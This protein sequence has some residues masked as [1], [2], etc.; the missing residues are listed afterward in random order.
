MRPAGECSRTG[1]AL[2][3]VILILAALLAIA[4]PLVYICHSN[5]TSAARTLDQQIARRYAL[6]AL[7]L[8]KG[9][10][11]RGTYEN[12][13]RAAYTPPTPPPPLIATADTMP[14]DT[15]RFDTPGELLVPQAELDNAIPKVLPNGDTVT[16]SVEVEDEQGKL[17]LNSITPE[18]LRGLYL[19]VFRI[20]PKDLSAE[21]RAALKAHFE[22]LIDPIAMLRFS[23]GSYAPLRS[24]EQIRNF[25]T[26]D[27]GTTYQLSE[28]EYEAMR[29]FLTVHSW[30]PS[31]DGFERTRLTEIPPGLQEAR[32]FTNCFGCPYRLRFYGSDKAVLAD[33]FA[34]SVD[35]GNAGAEI[36]FPGKPPTEARFSSTSVEEFHPVNVNTADPTVLLALCLAPIDISNPAYGLQDAIALARGIRVSGRV[37]SITSGSE[38]SIIELTDDSDD[39]ASKSPGLITCGGWVIS[40]TRLDRTHLECPADLSSLATAALH[41]L[42]VRT[43]VRNTADLFPTG[44]QSVSKFSAYLDRLKRPIV[45]AVSYDVYTVNARCS[46]VSPS[47]QESA[48]W[49]VTECVCVGSPPSDEPVPATLDTEADFIDIAPNSPTNRLRDPMKRRISHSWLADRSPAAVG[50]PETSP[51]SHWLSPRLDGFI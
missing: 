48:R 4:V 28:T 42:D 41:P 20:D 30:R 46:I 17:N 39:F 7:E 11:R 13:L 5:E 34:I 25:S 21:D 49:C 12:E 50:Y 35:A 10:L 26:T 47:G 44:G 8:A 18:I 51:P 23:S 36:P 29:P 6:S 22:H 1:V 33:S 19:A 31:A 3:M 38:H 37:K 24:V 40:F 9:Q 14:F 45:S 32:Y 15:P 16:V 27:S 2:I 43:V